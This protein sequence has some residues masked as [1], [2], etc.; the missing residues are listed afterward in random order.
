MTGGA[1]D[2]AKRG[3]LKR[4]PNFMEEGAKTFRERN[5]VY[6]NNY[7]THGEVMTSLF[8]WGADL[9]SVS[10]FNR[11]GIINM[12]VAKL[13]RYCHNFHA[14][15]HS[16]SIHDD[17]VYSFMLEELDAKLIQDGDGSDNQPATTDAPRICPQCGSR[18]QED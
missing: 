5:K 12:K 18:K 13:T 15:G 1:Y 14:G 7:H 16:D 2:A 8:P 10:D 4:A 6:G 11:F 9:K 3:E 17:G